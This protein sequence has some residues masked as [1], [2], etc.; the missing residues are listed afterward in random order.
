LAIFKGVR[1]LLG[2]NPPKEFAIMFIVGY[3]RKDRDAAFFKREKET[4]KW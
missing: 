1:A 3:L 4:K 2:L